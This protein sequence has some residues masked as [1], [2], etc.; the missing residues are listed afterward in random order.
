M[1]VKNVIPKH[2]DSITAKMEE[3]GVRIT[4][5]DD[6]VLVER[7]GRLSSINIKTLPYPGFPTDMVPQ[8][9]AVLCAAE[10][11][12][13]INEGIWSNRFRFA[14]E[15]KRMG[16][17]IQVNG[18]IA[19]IEGIE[20]LSGASVRACDLR[21]GAGMIIAG[22]AATGVTEIEEIFH[23]E[24]GYENIIEKLQALGA[25]IR[26]VVLPDETPMRGA[27]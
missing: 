20:K 14:D 4:E 26:R 6:S 2:L 27:I 24:R 18:K 16:A 1:L 10:G 13:Y 22:L 12:S 7:E 11:T 15:Y 21:A 25:N 23:I 3:A 19:V 17:Q 5:F 9:A 8:L